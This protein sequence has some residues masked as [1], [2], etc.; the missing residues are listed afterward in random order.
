MY[1]ID[2]GTDNPYFNIAAEEYLFSGFRDDLLIL[3][4]NSPSIIVGK[5]QNVYEEV[6]F[7]Y[8]R[9]KSLPVIR[10]ISGGGTVYHDHGNL[11]FTF[12]VN[13]ED[14]KQV[15]FSRFIKPV[16]DFLKN[17]GIIPEV[18]IKNEV[19]AGGLKFSGN[20]EHVFRSRVM[21]HGTILFSSLLDD[22]GTSLARGKASFKSRSVQSNR[23]RVGNLSG[24]LPD[25]S[26]TAMLMEEM[27]AF[28]KSYFPGSQ[29]RELTSGEREIIDELADRKYKSW[30][31]NYGYGPS[32]ELSNQVI[33]EGI[34]YDLLLK[35][36]KG[37]IVESRIASGPNIHPL[38]G[39]MAGVCHRYNDIC[40]LLE[41]ENITIEE[42]SLIGFF[43]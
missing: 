34:K 28:M 12:M 41:S 21:H 10:R 38:S 19:R 29:Q 15:N 5:H 43:W 26:S 22:L 14:G 39:L 9:E 7:Q 18:G 40:R 13:T 27:S 36:E 33:I 2:T 31:W 4:V 16:N 35:V 23:T 24:Y 6:N 32:Y 37:R 42:D 30:D 8:V 3:Y 20:A 11:N 17:L 25:I 1:L